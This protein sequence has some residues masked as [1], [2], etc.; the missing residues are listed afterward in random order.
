[1][2][3]QPHRPS[4]HGQLSLVP[5]DSSSPDPHWA[6]RQ[7][8]TSRYGR[9]RNFSGG[10]NVWGFLF[11]ERQIPWAILKKSLSSKTNFYFCLVSPE[12]LGYIHRDWSLVTS[13][14]G[15]VRFLPLRKHKDADKPGSGTRKH[16]Q[17][18][19]S[20][21]TS[22]KHLLCPGHHTAEMTGTRPVARRSQVTLAFRRGMRMEPDSRGVSDDLSINNYLRSVARKG[23]R[24]RNVNR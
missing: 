4:A 16:P 17:T 19:R 21:Q 7:S 18:I 8:T 6:G 13:K 3:E 10:K 14:D 5:T 15:S 12:D 11:P 20:K 9:K 23:R 24:G 22:M 1:M 2:K